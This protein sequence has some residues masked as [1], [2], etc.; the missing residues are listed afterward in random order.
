MEV[1]KRSKL[2]LSRHKTAE[3]NHCI[4][5]SNKSPANSVKFMYVG[6][7]FNKLL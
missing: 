2:K 3:Q 6:K 1:G 5:V 4:K 7:M